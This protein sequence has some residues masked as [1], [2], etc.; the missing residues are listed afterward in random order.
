MLATAQY[1]PDTLRRRLRLRQLEAPL[2]RLPAISGLCAPYDTLSAVL[3]GPPKYR[4]R[5][6]YRC[7]AEMLRDGCTVGLQVNHDCR[8]TLGD[9]DDGALQLWHDRRGLHFIA[10]LPSSRLG[11]DVF[12]AV[13]GRLFAGM[14]V[15]L[16]FLRAGTTS[17]ESFEGGYRIEEWRSVYVQ[18]VSFVTSP[19]YQTSMHIP[20]HSH[21]PLSAAERDS[22][23][24]LLDD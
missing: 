17:R 14:S 23:A 5:F 20:G 9:T 8:F 10:K 19:A 24:Y 21:R 6:A 12:R 4:E 1:D 22:L 11:Q 7:F 2:P 13:E 18:E 3:P 15:M 16:P